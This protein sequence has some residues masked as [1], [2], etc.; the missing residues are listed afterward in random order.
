MSQQSCDSMFTGVICARRISLMIFRMLYT[1]P[2]LVSF[3]IVK[4][5]IPHLHV[6]SK[7]FDLYKFCQFCSYDPGMHLIDSML[8]E[9]LEAMRIIDALSD[10]MPPGYIA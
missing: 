9:L 3:N 5:I 6:V 7:L 4:K 8:I 1:S 2:G 10:Y